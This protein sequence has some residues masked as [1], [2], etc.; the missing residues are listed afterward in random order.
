VACPYFLPQ[1]E[2]PTGLWVHEP[3][4]PLGKAYSGACCSRRDE[5]LQ[6]AAPHQEALCNYGYARG[7]CEHFPAD[8]PA[9]AVRFSATQE[10]GS[11]LRLVYVLEKDHV[12]AQFGMLEYDVPAGALLTPPP[13]PL[14]ARQAEAFARSYLGAA[15]TASARASDIVL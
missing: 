1:G 6:P 13:D 10:D 9:D 7:A 2:L 12:P 8:S 15:N 3:R 5:R 11:R 14:L 4:R